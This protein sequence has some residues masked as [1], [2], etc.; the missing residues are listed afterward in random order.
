ME[1]QHCTNCGFTFANIALLVAGIVLLLGPYSPAFGQAPD[2]CNDIL[3]DGLFNLD[4]QW[5]E[6][7][8]SA[9]YRDWQCSSSFKTHD[10]AIDAGLN[11]GFAVYG[12]PIQVGGTWSEDEK[13]SWKNENCSAAARNRSFASATYRLVRTVSPTLVEAWSSCMSSHYSTEALGC[14]LSKEGSAFVFSA[15][16]KRTRGED[17]AGAPEVT[18]WYVTGGRCE[19]AI[20]RA[21]EIGEGGRRTVC[22]A[23]SQGDMVILLETN[24]GGCFKSSAQLIE[25]YLVDGR[26]S[27]D[28]PL[29][30]R[31]EVVKLGPNALIVTNG[32]DLTINAKRDLILKGSP[33]IISFEPRQGRPAGD[34]GRDAGSIV[35]QGKRISGTVVQIDNSGEDGTKGA[36][37]SK[38]A[39]GSDGRNGK[40][41]VWK[42]LKGCVDRR[43]AGDGGRGGKGGKGQKGGNAGSGGP[44]TAAF[45]QGL[46]DGV[47]Q[48]VKVKTTRRDPASGDVRDCAGKTCSGTPGL[49]GPGGP[50]GDGGKGGRRGKGKGQCGDGK[51]G[52]NGNT[53]PVGNVGDT[54]GKGI[55]GAVTIVDLSQGQ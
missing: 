8:E 32:H 44:V 39:K 29:H 3:K 9:E 45:A 20:A 7:Q 37:G 53:G 47:I 4:Q 43:D 40:G 18:E 14:D 25:P 1:Q 21:S 46:T 28:R 13:R 51:A 27:L 5:D 49:G 52:R 41:G 54:G 26:L 38:G 35:L 15:R 12:V 11:V 19:P 34:P 48:R 16:W 55:E 30:I 2:R 42:D 24:R 33:R 10:E 31:E 36:Q 17:L 23:S 22:S 6:V 50:G